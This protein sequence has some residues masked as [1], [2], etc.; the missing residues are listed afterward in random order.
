M[1]GWLIVLIILNVLGLGINLA[2]HGE[3]RKDK[4]SFWSALI[5]SGLVIWLAYMAVVTGL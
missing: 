5:G 2:R 3:T 4:Y 1:N